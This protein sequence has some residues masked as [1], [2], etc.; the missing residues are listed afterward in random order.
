MTVDYGSWLPWLYLAVNGV[1]GLV[2]IVFGALI[3]SRITAGNAKLDIIHTTVNSNLAAKQQ[4]VASE[5]AVNADL[6]VQLAHAAAQITALVAALTP[7]EKVVAVSVQPT[8][9]PQS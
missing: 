7:S 5:Q 3:T 8:Q 6:R 2:V 1:I 9:G 4:E